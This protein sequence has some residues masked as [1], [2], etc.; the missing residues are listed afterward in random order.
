MRLR[1]FI[2]K[3]MNEITDI[4]VGTELPDNMLVLNKCILVIC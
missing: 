2:Q 3:K 4:E 1:Q